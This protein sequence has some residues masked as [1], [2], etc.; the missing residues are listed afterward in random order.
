MA[1]RAIAIVVST[2][3][4]VRRFTSAHDSLR[5][6]FLVKAKAVT[7]S[8]FFAGRFGIIFVIM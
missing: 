8:T 4:A 7:V 3:S 2:H 1:I 6:V 5:F